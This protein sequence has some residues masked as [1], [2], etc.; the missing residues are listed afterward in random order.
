MGKIENEKQ[1]QITKEWLEKFKVSIEKL[2]KDTARHPLRN[3]L[4]L[5]SFLTAKAD[6]E[7]QIT[8]YKSHKNDGAA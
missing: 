1:Y 4:L 7:E 2:K 6:F 5:A 3:E 8:E